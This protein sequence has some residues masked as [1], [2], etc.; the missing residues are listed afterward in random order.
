MTLARVLVHNV[1]LFCVIIVKLLHMVFQ[2]SM[3]GKFYK[4]MSLY[5]N[6]ILKM[7][8]KMS[9]K[10]Y[11]S[12]TKGLEIFKVRVHTIFTHLILSMRYFRIY[13]VTAVKRG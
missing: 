12:Q 8:T 3:N 5:D 10:D 9:V 2:F 7:C 4:Q 1:V 6:H 11:V 13:R